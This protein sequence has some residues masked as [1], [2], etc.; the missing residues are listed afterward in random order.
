MQ[1]APKE[2]C[3]PITFLR[4]QDG[5][6]AAMA[7]TRVFSNISAE[8]VQTSVSIFS[9]KLCKQKIKL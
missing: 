8:G 9:G 4:C 1:S 3:L 5:F 2:Q 6:V 7:K